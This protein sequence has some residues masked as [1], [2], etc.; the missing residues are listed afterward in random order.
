[1]WPVLGG[2]EIFSEMTMAVDSNFRGVGGVSLL[3]NENYAS[4]KFDMKMLLIGKDVW[5]IVTG[6]ETLQE[7]A[8]NKERTSFRKREN[9]ALSTIC[10]SVS[11][12]IKIYVR[13]SKTSKEAWDSLASHFEEKSLSKKIYYR[14]KLYNTKLEERSST[15]MVEHV[16][17]LKTISE[18]LE[19]L[20]DEV[21]EKDLVMI[22]M[23]SIPESYN[24][25]ITT[26]ETLREER[27]TWE[28]VRDRV[29]TEFERK[30]GGK[31]EKEAVLIER[32]GEN[33]LYTNGSKYKNGNSSRFKCH[34]C[35]DTGHFIR[36]CER[37]KEDERKEVEERKRRENEEKER[38]ESAA[39]CRSN[40]EEVNDF[41]PEFA[42]HVKEFRNDS[43]RWLLDSACSKHITGTRED[44][45]N[46]K[47]FTSQ[48]EFE[49]VTLADKSIVRAEG[50]GDL[51]VYL[52]DV[53]NKKVPITFRNVLF[54]PKFERL[55]SISQ[56]TE[57][58]NVEVLF[59][60]QSV[61]LLID[62]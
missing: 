21:L 61:I 54:I 7:S 49:Y 43:L 1:M 14:R 59:K 30:N 40:G 44:L 41:C 58:R 20:D 45:V 42:L 56:L 5:D 62:S 32:D 35:Q 39:F 38:E 10:L 11:S 2:P 55:I 52:L 53:N 33:A 15:T 50:R 6:E 4:W 60:S 34:Y 31:E 12:D 48:T 19:A 25:L 24:N 17:K 13:N 29:I 27:L 51:N 22:L 28:Y 16:N 9:H 3:T 37:K 47:K 8:T 26:L 36:D 18:H 57:S 23:S 46:F